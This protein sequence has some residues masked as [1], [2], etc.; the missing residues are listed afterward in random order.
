MHNE[1]VNETALEMTIFMMIKIKIFTTTTT[2]TTTT[3]RTNSILV[4]PTLGPP[5]DDELTGRPARLAGPH[6]FYARI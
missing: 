5:T 2:T 3:T 4:C 6:G 1:N